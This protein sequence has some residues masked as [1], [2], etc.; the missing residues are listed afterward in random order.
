MDEKTLAICAATL[1]LL[2]ISLHQ[3]LGSGDAGRSAQPPSVALAS[4]L[5]ALTASF[6][7]AHAPLDGAVHNRRASP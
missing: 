1:C 2:G 4:A 6:Y 3:T 7:G 5:P